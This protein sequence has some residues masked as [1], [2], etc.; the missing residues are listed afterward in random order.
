MGGLPLEAHAHAVAGIAAGN[1]ANRA[2]FRIK[3]RALFDMQFEI[4]IN[5]ATGC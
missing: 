5:T 2:P 1:D 4:G 3:D